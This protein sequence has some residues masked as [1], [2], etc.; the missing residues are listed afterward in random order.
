M[1]SQILL[2]ASQLGRRYGDRIALA[3][4]DL[5]LARGEVLGLLGPN[6]AGKSTTLRMLSG[7]LPP[8]SGRVRVAGIDLFERPRQ[9][10]RHLG[11][12]PELPPVYP[13]MR[14]ADY[15]RFCGRLHGLRGAPL[16]A[17]LARS[18]ERCGLGEVARRL[19]GNLSKGYQ[20]RVGIAQAI[21]HEPRVLILDEPTVGLDPLQMREIRALLGQLR[22]EHAII[23]SSHILPEIQALCE[24]VIILSRGR[25]VYE[26]ALGADSEPALEVML[27]CRGTPR[28]Q[29]L[30]AVAGVAGIEE[31]GG[32]RLR[33]QLSDAAAA[34][35]VQ[36]AVL[37][38]GWGIREWLPVQRNLEQ[39]F[40]SLTHGERAAGAPA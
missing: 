14:V 8:S 2:Q 25:M 10:K 40:V 1:S 15:L 34:E 19:I 9:A 30:A 3:G 28:L 4:L 31:L 37:A 24:R 23:L 32:G 17:A 20:Q 22:Q 39:L 21:L 29:V 6:G 7:T 12:L 27:S 26:G 35:R 36:Q 38:A 33:L 11:Y 13:E 5:S 16:E 18:L